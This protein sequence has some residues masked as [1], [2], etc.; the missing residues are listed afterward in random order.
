[1][2]NVQQT[3]STK[4]SFTP[5]AQRD[6]VTEFSIYKEFDTTS[7]TTRFS[8]YEEV[9]AS[10]SYS[11]TTFNYVPN[12][13]FNTQ[14]KIIPS[15]TRSLTARFNLTNFVNNR[16]SVKFAV[17]R[18]NLI[19][20]SLTI[21]FA[22]YNRIDRSLTTSYAVYGRFV[23]NSFTTLFSTHSG[24]SNSLT[25]SYGMTPQRTELGTSHIPMIST[26]RIY[27]V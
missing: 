16:L 10:D 12:I 25:I 18:G 3:F 26:N 1:M 2:P 20:S 22:A 27:I 14:W 5:S 9:R 11:F 6:F 7:L 15:V 17:L 19:T 24:V 21:P 23:Y 4:W 13:V 8:V